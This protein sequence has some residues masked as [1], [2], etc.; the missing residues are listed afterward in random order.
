MKA[1][2]PSS[3]MEIVEL[4]E[5]L[6]PDPDWQ[7]WKIDLGTKE[8]PLYEVVAAPK[9]HAEFYVTDGVV[10]LKGHAELALGGFFADPPSMQGADVGSSHRRW[11]T[12]GIARE[13]RG[14]VWRAR[15]A[16]WVRPAA[17]WDADGEMPFPAIRRLE[18]RSLVVLR[19]LPARLGASMGTRYLQ[20]VVS[21]RS[22]WDG[23]ALVALDD[24][25]DLSNWKQIHFVDSTGARVNVTTDPHDT[26]AILL[27]TA[28]E[29]TVRW[30]RP[31]RRTSIV[32]LHISPKLIAT[33]GRVSGVIDAELDGEEDPEARRLTYT[34]PD[35]RS[36]IREEIERLGPIKFAHRYG[37]NV[38]TAKGI[39]AG[40][41]PGPRTV[42]IVRYT[43]NSIAQPP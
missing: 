33:K 17:P 34:E 31:P 9:S 4:F 6:S 11:S 16:E 30:G 39:S 25:G 21:P 42:S 36:F 3:L 8:E 19:Q 20:P 22:R 7:V 10:E 37:V 14:L 2:S 35:V 28:D 27:E 24:G 5:P 23:S 13:V 15:G 43:L 41:R 29:R 18:M 26:S 38:N 40:K 32:A 12:A 1:L